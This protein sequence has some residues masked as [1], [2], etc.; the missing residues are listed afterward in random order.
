MGRHQIRA[1]LE[2]LKT[3][4]GGFDRVR[5]GVEL[6]KLVY[7]GV[8][9]LRRIGN[10]SQLLRNHDL[11]IVD[12]RT[13]RVSC[14]AGEPSRPL[15]PTEVGTHSAANTENGYLSQSAH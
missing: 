10:A 15:S 12:N 7:P 1:S 13:G 9:G 3:I 5:S 11:D 2:R 6:N 8:V 14:H 4:P